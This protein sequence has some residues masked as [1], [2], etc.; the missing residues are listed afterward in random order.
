MKAPG[1]MLSAA[2]RRGDEVKS[3]YSRVRPAPARIPSLRNPTARP[4][5]STDGP[6]NVQ[7]G[8]SESMCDNRIV[9]LSDPAGNEIP[10]SC[11]E[12]ENR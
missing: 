5:P 3:R 4:P 7:D 10:T 2:W 8:G 9:Y 6:R 11:P 12:D 1:V